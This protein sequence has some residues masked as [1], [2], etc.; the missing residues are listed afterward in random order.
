MLRHDSAAIGQYPNVFPIYGRRR[1]NFFAPRM[2]SCGGPARWRV[3]LT[4]C[5]FHPVVRNRCPQ[6]D[7]RDCSPRLDIGSDFARHKQQ[8]MRIVRRSWL[9]DVSRGNRHA[10]APIAGW[11]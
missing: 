5:P 9:D 11:L 6:M 4:V 1:P 10:V 3:A 2:P 8:T 7:G